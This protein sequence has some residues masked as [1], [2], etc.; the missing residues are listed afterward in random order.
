[1][2]V[3][4]LNSANHDKPDAKVHHGLVT[5][6]TLDEADGYLSSVDLSGMARICLVHHHPIQYSDPVPDEPDFSAM[7]NAGNL[8]DLLHKFRFD[9]LVHGHKHAPRLTTQ[10]INNCF[11][12]VIIGSGS[13][14][15]R[16]DPRWSGM[17]TN[18]FHVVKIE[19]RDAGGCVRGELLS[20]TYLSGHGWVPSEPNNGIAHRIPFGTH[21]S[22]HELEARIEPVIA[23]ALQTAEY[24]EWKF[25]V[26]AV[27]EIAFISP[28]T[29]CKIVD[30]LAHR[31]H[32]RR[33]GTPPDDVVLLRGGV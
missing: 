16:L 17:V 28:A 33:H 10:V 19:G 29:A 22:E 1:V 3:L 25:V 20:W 27:P 30:A 21:V 6:E 11:P 23:A 13:F 8:L 14:S 15:A 24:L 4:G 12:L 18:Q 32:F 31:L 26:A 9:V 7:T 5:Q 2:I